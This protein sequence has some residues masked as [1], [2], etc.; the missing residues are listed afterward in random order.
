MS[1]AAPLLPACTASAVRRR[2]PLMAGAAALMVMCAATGGAAQ[3]SGDPCGGDVRAAPAL[4]NAAWSDRSALV[5]E[6]GR[7]LVLDGLVLPSRLTP[8]PDVVAR[9]AAAADE[10]LARGP[11][12]LAA[13]TTDRHGRLVGGALLT[14]ETAAQAPESLAHALVAAGAAY[15]DGASACG[16]ALLA[17]EDEARAARRGLWGAREAVVRAD[18]IKS[19]RARAGLFT[20]IEGKV[21][22]TGRSGNTVYVNFGRR[23]REDVTLTLAADSLA[24]IFGEGLSPA[25]MTGTL[26]RARGIV[27]EDGGPA[28]QLRHAGELDILEVGA[29]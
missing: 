12:A 24:T 16:T 15:A 17:A 28:I 21:T 1:P 23:W 29:R 3:S 6:D 11:I 8:S 5:L 13:A 25:M 10:V 4:L 27:R 20:V 9:A 2:L 22:A 18:D 7:E 26:V 19:V 14:D